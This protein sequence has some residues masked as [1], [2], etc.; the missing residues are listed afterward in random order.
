MFIRHVLCK[1]VK[2]DSLLFGVPRDELNILY[3][4]GKFVSMPGF[5]S[6]ASSTGEI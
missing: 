3:Y 6:A 5:A 4:Q 1:N 2:C